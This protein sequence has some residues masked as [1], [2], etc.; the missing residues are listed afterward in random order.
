MI[1]HA[2]QKIHTAYNIVEKNTNIVGSVVERLKHRT[3]DQPGLGFKPM[4]HSVVSLG[5][6]LYGTFL[7][8]VILTSSFK[9]Q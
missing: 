1:R 3:D 9:L 6:T 7:S 4:R 8:L 5:K 2:Y